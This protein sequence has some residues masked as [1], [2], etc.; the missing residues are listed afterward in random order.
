MD[1]LRIVLLYVY[2]PYLYPGC[3][4]Y[5][6]SRKASS[7]SL[8]LAFAVGKRVHV[9]RWI[10]QEEWISLNADTA[11]G[12]EGVM[13]LHASESPVRSITL[14]KAPATEAKAAASKPVQVLVGT[15][16]SFELL[17]YNESAAKVFAL[18]HG[19]DGAISA[20][21]VRDRDYNTI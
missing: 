10:H 19:S 13:E 12:F 1:F 8:H 7:T 17:R 20:I 21:Q 15:R 18:P 3:S 14:L 6:L 9:M 5:S 2:D 11:E 4:L 16:S